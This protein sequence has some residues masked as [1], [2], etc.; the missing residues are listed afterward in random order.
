[1]TRNSRILVFLILLTFL[2][3]V[4]TPGLSANTELELLFIDV[5]QGDSAL[6]VFPTGE[7]MLID[8]GT[9]GQVSKVFKALNAR[10]I[11][12]IDYVV[13]SH[14]HEDH[15]DGL[16]DVLEAY[17]VGKVLDTGRGAKGSIYDIFILEVKKRNIP[18]ETV[19][20]NFVIDVGSVHLNILSPANPI[21]NDIDDTSIVISLEYGAFSALFTGDIGTNI[22]YELLKKEKIKPVT[23]LK[24]AHHGSIS[25]SSEA[26]LNKAVPQYAVVSVGNDNGYGHPSAFVLMRY[27]VIGAIVLRTDFN[28]NIGFKTN[29]YTTSATVEKGAIPVV[30]KVIAP[31]V[32]YVASKNSEV[33]HYP[34]CE[35]VKAI[36][37]ENLIGFSSRDQAVAS[38][39]RP[40][41]ICKP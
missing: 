18:I 22:E 25:S 24:V 19:R 31:Q 40:C 11:E 4:I 37:P 5:G 34:S 7:T 9:T 12:K 10:N 17:K 26:F 16:I 1:M 35:S 8:A 33:F 14:A 28:G 13:A 29:G 20:E 3:L 6:I 21:S 27:S 32:K 36:K 41:S 23:V 39:R 2:G 38:G 15:I 30:Q